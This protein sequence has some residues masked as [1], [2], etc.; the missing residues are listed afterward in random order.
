M[1]KTV[2][3][4][5]CVLIGLLVLSSN[6]FASHEV[7]YFRDNKK[8]AVS[9]TF[10]DGYQSPVTNGVPQMNAR[11]L[12][13][14]FFPLTSW[15]EIS[16]DTLRELARQGH[17]IGSH[18]VTHPHLTTLSETDLRW[19]LKESQRIINLD[20]PSDSCVSF[21]YPYGES[22]ETIRA[23][24][25]EYYI[26]GRG[27]G[28]P[29]GGY[30]NYYE[31]G[32]S[33][34]TLNFF[35]VGSYGISEGQ[36]TIA[37]IDSYLNLAV[38]RHAWYCM[39]FHQIT[40]TNFFT[41]ILNQ[42]LTKDVW[43]DTFGSIVRYMRERLFSTIT[44]LSESS[45]AITLNLTHSLD[46]SIYN[47]PL[48]MRSTIP[49]TWRKV[50]V[51]QG[52][53]VYIVDAITEGLD[54]VIYYNVVP[55][56]GTI[57][58][59]LSEDDPTETVS[60]PSVPSGP[61]GGTEGI[62][63]A[64]FTGG[65]SSTHGH[66]VEYQF[67]W[68][69]DGETDLSPWGSAAQSKTW[70]A[71]GTYNVRARARCIT[72]RGVV[73]SWSAAMAVN[74]TLPA[75]SLLELNFEEGSGN[76]ALDSSGYGN[77][78]TIN[79]AVYTTDSAVG[80][81]ALSFNGN[82]SVVVQGNGSLVPSNISV[83]FWVKHVSDT[84]SSYGG[85]VQGAYGSGYSAGFRV[86]DYN[87]KPLVQMNFG[88]SGPIGILG[89]PF[90]QG[91]W[92]H[93]VLMYDHAKIKLYQNGVLVREVSETRN[94]N[95]NGSPSNLYI[96]LAQWYF[97]GVLDKVKIYNYAL[98]SQEIAQLYAEK[99]NPPETVSTPS[100]LTGPT[101]GTTGISYDYSTGGSSSSLNHSVEYQFDWKGDG[102]DLSSWGSATQS[103]TWTTAG[104]YS[105]RA[106]ARCVTH[107]GVVSAW[108]SPLTVNITQST[109]QY[110][111]TVNLVGSGSVT[112]SPDKAQYN[113]G[114]VVQLT[115]VPATGWAFSGWSGDLT[116][117]T[118]P[119]SITMNANKA[120]TATFVQV[121]T[122]TVNVTGSGSVTKN[123]DKAQYNSGEVVQ[124]TAVPTTGWVFSG[125]SG[126]LSGTT[127]P[128]SITMSGPKSVVA[129]FTSTTNSTLLELNFEEGSGSTALDSSGYGNNGIINGAVYTT[130]SAVG[131]YALS[132]N[133]NGTVT[134]QANVSLKPTDISVA[135]WVKHVSD[136]SSSYGGIIQGAYGNGYHTGFRILDYINQPL[137]QMNF[138]DSGPIGMLGNPFIQGEWCHIVFTYD[139]AKIRL[140]QNGVLVRE[141]AETRDINWST[142]LSNLYIGLAQWY[143]KGSIDKVKMFNY[144]LSSQ[145][146]GQLYAEKGGVPV[147]YTLTVN[148]MGSGSVTKNPDKAQYNSGD[149]VQLTAVPA[150]GWVF[151]GWSG[152]LTGSTNPASITMSGPRSVVANFTST[153]NSTLLE[154]N[155][156]EG[157]GSTALD[158]SGY[159]NNGTIN[160]AVY[161]TDS[162]VGSYALSF[163]GNGSVAVQGNGS[164]KPTN[165]SVA[166]WVKHV[167]DTSSSYGGIIQ[168][169][170]GNGYHTGFRILDYINQPLAQMNFGDSGPIG[171][172]G[173]PFVQ[174]EW[175]HIVVTYDHAKIGLYQNGV[176]VRETAETRNINWSTN[177]SN[178]YIGLA[179]WYFNGVIDKVKMYNYA[180]SS[181]EIAQ[182]YNEK[183][184]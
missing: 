50:D 80:S 132:F 118:N 143:F 160:G 127:T 94:I 42:L 35:N 131:S 105:V 46:N 70:M 166:F 184:K 13:G 10:D 41:Q 22:N 77:N 48:T 157:S 162:A 49:T 101:S 81:Y 173:N 109:V 29:E 21:A 153:T 83:A 28:S 104:S 69:G 100:F 111:L 19:E 61:A 133:G 85:I 123:P 137:A 169:A 15:R 16:L 108:S 178:L 73:S 138:G 25:S 79:G 99:P 18:S 26:A 121:Y 182:L 32:P 141:T 88:D 158:S 84:S 87:N 179:Q 115:A 71:A 130:D 113:S 122:L 167:S 140:Y 62:S 56:K 164:L 74:I 136:T 63:Y 155:F 54:T 97:K 3:Y 180:L 59:T 145:E 107:T 14:T 134:V 95:W 37:D 76:T 31:D 102:T 163:N 139:H 165:I 39:Y 117:S 126:D 72:D 24:T 11:N 120:A 116:G 6:T 44:V 30:L 96:G 183:A 90:V 175:C 142:N 1:K 53:N 125:W 27:I 151:S 150:T 177:L 51:Q 171:M 146:V 92:S 17:E 135:L 93:I 66:S 47:E 57:T 156:E 89:N 55:N 65:S 129:N 103:K 128:A 114:D 172:L 58:L 154:L 124:L 40:D 67:D 60:T 68:K 34:K 152:D 20:V 168:G 7:T 36:T 86:L 5:I 78:G 23:I 106:K 110:T 45:T 12:K 9:L 91:V 176:L 174:G 144:A 147:Q 2:L 98:S 170:Y 52:D 38:Q 75:G 4:L 82:G 159:G 8:G 148:I 149:V 181:Q 119:T 161:T 64:Y 112:K 33:W 43:I